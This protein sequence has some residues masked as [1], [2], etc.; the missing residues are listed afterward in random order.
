MR[1]AHV[2]TASDMQEIL[3][4]AINGSSAS[5]ADP[6]AYAAELEAALVHM[7][8]GLFGDQA[9]L[10]VPIDSGE[11]LEMFATVLRGRPWA[12]PCRDSELGDE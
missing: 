6:R 9:R 8:F 1:M 10:P 11:V 4:D 5:V 3:I 2:I 12:S 7:V